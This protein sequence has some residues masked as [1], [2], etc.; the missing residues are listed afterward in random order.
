MIT[1]T[2]MG[3]LGNQLSQYVYAKT[4][5]KRTGLMYIPPSCFVDKSHNPIQWTGEPLFEMRPTYGRQVHYPFIQSR[6]LHWDDF[7]KY[8]GSQGIRLQGYAQRYEL[9]RDFK[10]EIRNDWLKIDVNKFID[11]SDDIIVIHVRLT[12]YVTL[13]DGTPPDPNR[14]GV[15]TSIGEFCECLE[16]FPNAKGVV[17]VT[18]DPDSPFLQQFDHCGLPYTIS[19]GTWEED[20][21]LL[22]SCRNMIMSQSTF[23]WWAAFLGRCERVVCPMFP[24]SFWH[25]GLNLY[26][27]ATPDFPNLYVDDEPERWI[28]ATIC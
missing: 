7:N 23:S 15:S 22:A 5:A 28:W 8:D 24:G 25:H 9:I 12:D 3:Q 1:S 11:V 10:N 18:D 21:M 19:R 16:Y 14:N 13:D 27:P 20:F 2:L 4:L 17:I 26:G 6:F